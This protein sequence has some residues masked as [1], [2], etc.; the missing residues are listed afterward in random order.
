M[1]SAIFAL[2][3]ALLAGCA[4]DIQTAS[5]T[6]GDVRTTNSGESTVMLTPEG[7]GTKWAAPTAYVADASNDGYTMS[8]S[9]PFGGTFVS[10]QSVS[11]IDTKNL[12]G[13]GLKI[14]YTP[15]GHMESFTLDTFDANASDVVD[16]TVA[17]VN[18]IVDY[19]KTVPEARR[20]AV[21][22]AIE[23]QGTFAGQL[24]SPE[25]L[26]LVKLAFGGV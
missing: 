14:I 7:W 12:S 24:L 3:I 8:G 18:A 13:T 10:G 19:L 25:V 26:S 15:D 6:P 2:P 20:D 5:F 11:M 9:T 17:L 16:A 21:L 22:A 1:K 23:A 4:G